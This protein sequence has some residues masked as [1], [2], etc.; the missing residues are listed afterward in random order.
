MIRLTVESQIVESQVPQTVIWQG[1]SLP[2][3]R[4][5]CYL[6]AGLF[7]LLPGTGRST[8]MDPIKNATGTYS[9]TGLSPGHRKATH[10]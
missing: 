7:L 1:D 3:S 8:L 2:G 4:S 10:H 9:N 6:V 5:N